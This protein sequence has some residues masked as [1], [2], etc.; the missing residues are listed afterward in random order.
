MPS[1]TYSNK[2]VVKLKEL[3][4]WKFIHKVCSCAQKVSQQLKKIFT[5]T[6]KVILTFVIIYLF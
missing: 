6:I 1:L 3:L 4:F 2:I 5:A